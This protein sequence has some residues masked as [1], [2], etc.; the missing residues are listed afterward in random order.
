MALMCATVPAVFANSAAA[1]TKAGLV[2]PLGS[3]GQWRQI[4]DDEFDGLELDRANWTTCYWWD[5]HGCTNLSTKEL[6]WYMPGNV[7]VS[8]GV[9]VLTA[10][11]ETVT[12][13][14]GRSFAFTS[15]MVTTG[16]DYKELPRAPRLEL[17]YG[18]IDVRAKVPS[19]QGLWPALWLL[20]SDRKSIPEIDIME[21]LGN[22]TKQLEL[23]FH[24]R[25]RQDQVQIEGKSV[26]TADLADDWHVYGLR[27]EPKA[28]VWYLDGVEQ[29]RYTD[30]ANIPDRSM[31]LLMNLA[32]GGSWP[33]PPDGKT[34]F[35]AQFLVDYVRIWQRAQP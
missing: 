5:D 21:V 13:Y 12:G 10:R 2:R 3:E 31:Y 11:P 28:V 26:T 20:P 1:E 24:F 16:R 15:G 35:P 8:N 29:W 32:V 33:G 23:H 17:L 34:K 6:Q 22:A 7:E 30:A 14:K 25:D 4:F 9:L 18:Q 19:G 27:W